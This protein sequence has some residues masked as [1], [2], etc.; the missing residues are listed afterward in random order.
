M[1]VDA[2]AAAVRPATLVDLDH[3][4][5]LET[6]FPGD[7][8]SRRSWRRLLTGD[9]A[10]VRVVPVPEGVSANIVCLTRR[11]SPWWR[12]YSLVVAPA[13]RGRG[14]A[15][16]LIREAQQAVS[17]ANAQGLRLEVRGD[18]PAAIALYRG[19][20]FTVRHPLSGYYEDGA[21]GLALQWPNLGADSVRAR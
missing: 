9:S 19:L 12:I 4:V 16:A 11:N 3:L 2:P 1:S 21:D 5:A 18:N 15:Q 6:L 13:F 10:W 14:L 17:A 8:L 7:R 20:G